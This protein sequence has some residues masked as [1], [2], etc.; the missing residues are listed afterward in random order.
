MQLSPFSFQSHFVFQGILICVIPIHLHATHRNRFV[1]F[2]K[3]HSILRYPRNVTIFAA[4]PASGVLPVLNGLQNE[5]GALWSEPCQL[6]AAVF[7]VFYFVSKL[8]RGWVPGQYFKEVIPTSPFSVT[9]MI[10]HSFTKH[11]ASAYCVPGTE[12]ELGKQYTA[13]L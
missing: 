12:L 3:P 11:L 6:L 7:F 1:W 5:A 9:R 8:G 10:T 2:Q 13:R 4:S